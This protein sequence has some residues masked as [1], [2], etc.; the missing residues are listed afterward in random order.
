LKEQRAAA[1]DADRVSYKAAK[2]LVPELVKHFG[3]SLTMALDE[4]RL[5]YGVEIDSVTTMWVA[6]SQHEA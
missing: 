2:R 4:R 3:F 6:G 1:A 5:L